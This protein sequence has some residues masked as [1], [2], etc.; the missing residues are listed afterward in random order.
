MVY[1]KIFQRCKGQPQKS[2]PTRSREPEN[3]KIPLL[4]NAKAKIANFF[5]FRAGFAWKK[6]GTLL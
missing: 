4:T 5:C 6:M 2:A 3:A 1:T